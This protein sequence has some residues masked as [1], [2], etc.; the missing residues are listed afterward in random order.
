VSP[1]SVAPYVETPPD[2]FGPPVAA[3]RI[4]G[5]HRG[6]WVSTAIAVDDGGGGY[7]SPIRIGVTDESLRDLG[8]AAPTVVSGHRIRLLS[9][10]T[11]WQAIATTDQPTIVVSGAVDLELLIEV[12]D[13]ARLHDEGGALNVELTAMPDGYSTIVGPQEH[14]VDTP[15][16][17][18]FAGTATDIVINEVS[19][20]VRADLAAAATG[21][22]FRSVPIGELTGYT[23]TTDINPVG[24]VTFL[25]W[26]P[27]PGVVF[28]IDT[29]DASLPTDQLVDLATRVEVLP[30]DQ[31]DLNLG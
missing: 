27:E 29:T 11:D 20:W 14:A 31:W 2:W 6:A 9:Y 1:G 13:A 19:E 16:R 10:G 24:P 17:R 4:A 23:G 26:S 5:H 15:E 3:E 7:K 21:A 25:I 30:I 22:D 18:T 8:E 28:E 12:L